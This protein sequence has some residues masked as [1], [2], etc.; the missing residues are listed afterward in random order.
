MRERVP[1]LIPNTECRANR[2]FPTAAGA[3]SSSAVSGN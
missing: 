2:A 3:S 1:L